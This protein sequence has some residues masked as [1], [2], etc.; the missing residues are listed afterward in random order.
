MFNS[1]SLP[2]N[3]L[4]FFLIV[5]LSGLSSCVKEYEQTHIIRKGNINYDFTFADL[6][7]KYLQTDDSTYLQKIAE[8]KATE[9]II[10]HAKRFNYNVPKKSKIELVTY[11]LSP[12][13]EKKEILADFKRNLQYAKKNIAEIDLTQKVCLEYFPSG[14]EFKSNVFFTFGYDLGVAFGKNASVNLAHPHYLKNINEIKYYSIHE[15]HHAGF[16]M[17]KNNIM[18]S[19]NINNYREMT[20]LIA[21]FTH[22]EGMGTFAPL[23]IRKKEN[24]MNIDKDYTALQDS[25]LMKEYEKEFFDIYFHFKNSPDSLLTEKDWEK[26][27]VLSDEK[28]LWYRVGASMAQSIDINLGRD[29]LVRLIEE[30]SENF[31]STYL[32]I[33]NK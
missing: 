11:L 29:K 28:R 27:S 5:L 23:D 3:R 6:A 22:L 2:M 24:A 33:K 1:K 13:D 25:R 4:F 15:L 30:D 12:A 18:P 17:L 20:Q 7:V 19:L 14:F 10:N 8:L 32:L 21:Y 26:V 16:V 9:H 31:I